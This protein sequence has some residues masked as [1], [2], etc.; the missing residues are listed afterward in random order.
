T[1]WP[2]TCRTE[3]PPGRQGA[4]RRPRPAGWAPAGP[5]R[6]WRREGSGTLRRGTCRIRGTGWTNT[7]VNES[8]RRPGANVPARPATHPKYADRDGPAGPFVESG[9][10]AAARAP[11]GLPFRAAPP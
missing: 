5:R 7:Q 6:S 2:A 10:L 8:T 9:R 3:L 4:V 11:H 1:A